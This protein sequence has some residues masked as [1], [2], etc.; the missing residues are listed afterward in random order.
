M[1]V[2]LDTNVLVSG[3]FFGGIPGKVVDAWLN[4]RFIAYITPFIYQEYLRTIDEIRLKI[5]PLINRDWPVLLPELCPMI[6]DERR[7]KRISRDRSDDKFVFCAMNAGANF[8]VTGD[9]D[10]KSLERNFGFKIVSPREFLRF[11]K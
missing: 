8:L 1:K 5:R 4:E 11:S 2:V 7:P 3:I 6:P 10:L 9:K